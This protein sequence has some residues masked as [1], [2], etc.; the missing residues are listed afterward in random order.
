MHDGLTACTEHFGTNHSEVEFDIM[1][2]V[3][4]GL[5]QRQLELSQDIVQGHSLQSHHLG[6]LLHTIVWS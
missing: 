4:L 6:T 1:P 2:Y 5:S 3:E